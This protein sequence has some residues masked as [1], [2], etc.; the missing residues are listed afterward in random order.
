MLKAIFID[1][2]GTLIPDIPFNVNPDLIV[3]EEGVIDGLVELNS[4][5][6]L[7]IIISNQS[8]IAH[9]YFPEEEMAAVQEHIA[10][11]LLEKS[12][13]LNGFYY[14]PHY[15]GAA[16]EKYNKIC[17]CRKPMPGLILQAAADFAIDL[18]QSWM[19]GDILNDVEAGNRAG[20]RTILID[21]GNETEWRMDTILRTPSFM[22]KD[23]RQAARFI[24]S[25]IHLMETLN[26]K[27]ENTKHQN[28]TF[29]YE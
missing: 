13:R 17:S 8:G 2:D 16:V 10:Q 26:N 23:M 27:I 21:N 11:R 9:G 20:C 3:L 24:L 4:K 29:L 7:F 18:S 6:Y 19:I 14:C 1:K 25:S 28:H 5:G 22:A 15:P 12:I